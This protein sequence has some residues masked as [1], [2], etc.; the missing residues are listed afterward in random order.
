MIH[1]HL[2]RFTGIDFSMERTWIGRHRCCGEILST[3]N[4][5]EICVTDSCAMCLSMISRGLEGLSFHVE[6]HAW[7]STKWLGMTQIKLRPLRARPSQG[8]NRKLAVLEWQLSLWGWVEAFILNLLFMSV[9]SKKKAWYK[10]Y[11][12]FKSLFKKIFEGK[13]LFMIYPK[14]LLQIIFEFKLYS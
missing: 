8:K 5:W 11:F 2:I 9:A 6:Q 1:S 7:I 14:N 12:S 13:C 4:S 10:W 3:N